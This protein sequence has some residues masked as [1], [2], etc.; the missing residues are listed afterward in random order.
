MKEQLEK[1]KFERGEQY[2]QVKYLKDLGSFEVEGIEIQGKKGRKA[3]VPLW[4][5][6]VLEKKEIAERVDIRR[7]PKAKLSSA[8]NMSKK[9][10]SFIKLDDLSPLDIADDLKTGFELSTSKMEWVDVNDRFS[11]FRDLII[12]RLQKQLKFAKNDRAV[13]APLEKNLTPEE[14]LLFSEISRCVDEWKDVL[15]KIHTRKY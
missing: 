5:A 7:Y 8:L 2:V 4:V 15:L 12:N 11:T 14:K 13:R 10:G 6:R 1:I 9:N 3:S